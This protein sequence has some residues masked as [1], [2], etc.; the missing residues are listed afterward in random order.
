MGQF[1]LDIETTGLDPLKDKILTIQYQELDRNT[2]EPKGEL[3]ILKEWESSE[4]EIIRQ[5]IRNTNVND[6]YPFSFIAVGYNL[7]FEH[8]FL[9]QRAR[10]HHLEEIDIL[11]K[12]FV[13]LRAIGILMNNGEFKGS[14]L[15]KITGKE[16]TGKNVPMWYNNGEYELIIRY[17]KTETNEFI[18]FNKWLYKKM[19]EML[20]EFKKDTGLI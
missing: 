10:I 16:G 15:D 7:T 20:I 19:P 5:F 8:N 2:G 9:K 4:E 12:P 13:D 11:N 14:G 17:I 18:K 1:Y 6:D 3:V